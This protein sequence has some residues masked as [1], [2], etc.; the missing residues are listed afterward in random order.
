MSNEINFNESMKR[1]NDYLQT[2]KAAESKNGKEE[3]QLFDVDVESIFSEFKGNG[4]DAVSPE[5]FALA[6]AEGFLE[7]DIKDVKS[8][9][10]QYINDWKDLATFDD[11]D[12][13]IIFN[14]VQDLLDAFRKSQLPEGWDVEDGVVKTPE[15]KEVEAK[16]SLED[17][18]KVEDG[19]HQNHH[20]QGA[21]HASRGS[22]SQKIQH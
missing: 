14:E 15:G 8:L 3:K 21:T 13:S 4:S 5:Q 7:K 12:D 6:F 20:D 22:S 19:K 16:P 18:H 2:Q 11:D 1:I 10:T 9:D 17:G